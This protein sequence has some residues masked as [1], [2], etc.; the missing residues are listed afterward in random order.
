MVM[1]IANSLSHDITAQTQLSRT[2][3]TAPNEKALEE[4]QTFQKFAAGTFY[5]TMFKAL[6]STERETKY[7]NGGRAEK[8]FRN[9]FDQHVASTMAEEHGSPFAGPL[10]DQYNAMRNRETMLAAAATPLRTHPGGES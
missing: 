6:R 8:I 10:F 5:Q 1:P 9:E 7:F 4:R 2:Q 3:T